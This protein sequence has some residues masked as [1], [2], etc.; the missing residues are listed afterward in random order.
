MPASII[1][2]AHEGSDD[3]MEYDV[4]VVFYLQRVDGAD[5]RYKFGSKLVS[6]INLIRSCAESSHRAVG[7]RGLK[8]HPCSQCIGKREPCGE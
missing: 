1:N 5:Q 4:L 7:F 8:W 3:V 2:N 6:P